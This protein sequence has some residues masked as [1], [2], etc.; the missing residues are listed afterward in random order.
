MSK[1]TPWRTWNEKVLHRVHKSPQLV[2]WP[3]FTSLKN[4]SQLDLKPLQDQTLSS[5]CCLRLGLANVRSLQVI[6]SKSVRISNLIAGQHMARRPN[7]G[8]LSYII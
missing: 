1:V 2:N 3:L 8:V 4:T 7:C 5:L 6:Q